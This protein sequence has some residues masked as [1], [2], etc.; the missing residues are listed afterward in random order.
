MT[1]KQQFHSLAKMIKSRLLYQCLAHFT[2]QEDM[3]FMNHGFALPSNRRYPLLL[4]NRD[5][6]FRY[7][8]QL[9]HY[10]ASA[11]TLRGLRVLDIGSGRG[12]GASFIKRYLN[13]KEVIGIDLSRKAI[14]KCN[15]YFHQ[16]GL[17]FYAGDA[18]KLPFD[19][20]YFDAAITIES[21][22]CYLNQDKFL[23]E[24]NRVLRPGGHLLF[25]DLQQADLHGTI[26]HQL[27]EHGFSILAEEDI[28]ENIL[29][30][31][32]SD[33]QRK[34]AILHNSWS[35]RWLHSILGNQFALQGTNSYENFR[36]RKYCYCRYVVQKATQSMSSAA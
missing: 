31:L 2:K 18:E 22:H 25:A 17:Y 20:H 34:S 36:K 12:G 30:S 33:H 7:P 1:I 6:P 21:S 9:Y 26:Q 32:D 24:V 16:E 5:E 27:L 19:D 4:D 11:V 29:A 15:E 10:V 3:L 35:N 14:Q 8:I 28:T 13:P 23:A